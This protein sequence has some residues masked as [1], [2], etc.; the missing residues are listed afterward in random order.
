MILRSMVVALGAVSLTNA[1]RVPAPAADPCRTGLTP[2]DTARF[3]GGYRNFRP[4]A[5]ATGETRMWLDGANRIRYAEIFAGNPA[6]V[7]EGEID[8]APDATWQRFV[9]RSYVDGT[10]R[11]TQTSERISDSVIVVRGG[12][13]TAERPALRF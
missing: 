2:G 3:I 13:R 1:P 11:D 12:A 8:I 5:R 7:W 6:S 9:W 10:L 4:G